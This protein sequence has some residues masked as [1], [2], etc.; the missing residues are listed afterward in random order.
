MR[1]FRLPASLIACIMV[2]M[3]TSCSHFSGEKTPAA[4]K[5]SSY[6]LPLP[7][8]LS[9]RVYPTPQFIVDFYTDFDKEYMDPKNP[10]MAYTPGE[11][12]LKIIRS[13]LDNIPEK[14]AHDISPR[15]LGVFFIE[16]LVGSAITDFLYDGKDIYTFIVFNPKVLRMN[17][18][19]WI[20]EKEKS[21]FEM[22]SPEYDLKI[23]I[24]N[25]IPGFYYIFYHEFAHAYDYVFK[26][27]PGEKTMDTTEQYLLDLRNRKGC[28]NYPFV[29]R[30][31]ENYDLP[32]EGTD[33]DGRDRITF[34]GLNKGPL[35]KISEARS[36]YENLEGSPY[37]SLYGAQ[38]WME[39]FAEYVAMYVSVESLG[40]PWELSLTKNGDEIYHASRPINRGN[41][42]SRKKLVEEIITGDK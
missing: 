20:T 5:L 27:T 36:I 10:Y 37:V 40:R 28:G 41:I 3:T 4:K 12:E 8:K 38:S 32:H 7:E 42:A 34:Y 1:N 17:A 33:F 23:D 11:E 9:A 22:D 29:C 15:F 39:D 19:D 35:M 31:W 13:V 26:V 18:S 25:D 16:N 2:F 24:G 14:M 21:A 30:I 6:N